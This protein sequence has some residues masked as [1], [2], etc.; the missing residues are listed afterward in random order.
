V[1]SSERAP[2]FGIKKLPYQE[3]K[4]KTLTMGPKGGLDTKT[5]SSNL[6][7]TGSGLETAVK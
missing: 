3:N 7:S 2:H 4:K 6:T 5:V 1:L